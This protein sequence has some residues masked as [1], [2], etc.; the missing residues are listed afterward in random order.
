MFTDH[1][2]PELRMIHNL[3][4]GRFANV[5]ASPSLKY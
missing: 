5:F 4:L 2:Q 1:A 3:D